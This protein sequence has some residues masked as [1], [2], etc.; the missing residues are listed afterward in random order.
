MSEQWIIQAARKSGDITPNAFRVVVIE[1]RGRQTTNDFPNRDAAIAY[2]N[3]AASEWDDEPILAYVLD[4][5][6]HI[7]ARGA[8][9]YSD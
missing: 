6:F 2:A 7:I 9:Y 1:P 8:P 4:D 3:D 5:E